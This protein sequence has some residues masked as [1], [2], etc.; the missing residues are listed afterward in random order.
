M[1]HGKIHCYSFCDVRGAYS[2]QMIPL[3]FI[4]S[5]FRVPKALIRA[6]LFLHH[7]GDKGNSGLGKKQNKTKTTHSFKLLNFFGG[8]AQNHKT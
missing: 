1:L 8:D 7:D 4:T 3:V 5:K 2:C 6:F